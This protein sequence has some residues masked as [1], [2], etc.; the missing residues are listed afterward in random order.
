MTA[1]SR[2]SPDNLEYKRNLAVYATEIA[3]AQIELKLFDKAAAEL[4]KVIAM[5][6]PIADADKETTTYQYDIGVAHRLLAKASFATG[7][8]SRQ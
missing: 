3:R 1:L 7:N 8:K 2:T 6:I 5:M 4:Q